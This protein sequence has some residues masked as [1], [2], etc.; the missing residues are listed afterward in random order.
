MCVDGGLTW[1]VSLAWRQV[2][3]LGVGENYVCCLVIVVIFIGLR[4]S[5]RKGGLKSSYGGKLKG[6]SHKV[7]SKERMGGGALFM[8]KLTPQAFYQNYLPI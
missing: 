5:K 4:G 7:K 2:N 6:R 1:G 8:R 3:R